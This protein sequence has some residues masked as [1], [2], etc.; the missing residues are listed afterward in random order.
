MFCSSE[1]E[2]LHTEARMSDSFCSVPQLLQK[3]SKRFKSHLSSSG[4]LRSFD[5]QLVISTLRTSQNSENLIFTAVETINHA[6]LN[7]IGGILIISIFFF[8]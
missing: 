4:I 7:Y 3:N 2:A 1:S 5:W 8:I 6:F